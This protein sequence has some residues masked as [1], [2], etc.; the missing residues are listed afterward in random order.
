MLSYF[1][2]IILT[3][4]KP[5]LK[6]VTAAD[7]ASSLYYFHLNTEDDLR[8]LEDD[9][10]DVVGETSKLKEKPLP[11]KPLPGSARSSIDL[12]QSTTSISSNHSAPP[13][14]PR[15]KPVTSTPLA[16]A[17]QQSLSQE[18]QTLSRRPLGP[19]PL[20]L[21]PIPKREILSGVENRPWTPTAR[22]DDSA[23]ASRTSYDTATSRPSGD[24]VVSKHG[25]NKDEAFSIT[26]IRRDPSSGAQWNVGS[27]FGSPASKELNRGE[28]PR[29]KSK[30]THS[31]ISVQILTP[32][33]GTFRVPAATNAPSRTSDSP[34]NSVDEVDTDS[35]QTPVGSD[36]SFDRQVRMEGASFW[37]RPSIQHRRTLTDLSGKHGITHRRGSSGSSVVEPA[38]SSSYNHD[39]ELDNADL[40]SKGYVFVSP[41]GGRCKFSTGSGGRSLTLKHALPAPVSAG[42]TSDRSSQQISAPVSE[43]RFNLPSTAFFSSSDTNSSSKRSS[44]DSK[45]TAAS[46]IRNLRKKLSPHK[47]QP[48]LPPRPHPTSYAALYPSDEDGPPLPPRSY[49]VTD[50]SEEEARPPLPTRPFSSAHEIN[51]TDQEIA[52]HIDDDPHLDLSIGQE[53]AGGGNRGKRAKLGKLVIHHEGF[54]MLDLVVAANIGIWWSV[55]ES[56]RH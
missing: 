36:W 45:T 12:A 56:G 53:K 55:W 40:Q 18:R 16:P 52:E 8:F 48:Q 6:N 3:T 46:A 1:L 17:L 54:K 19:R 2:D 42:G 25:A 51:A 30:K 13:G 21:D 37:S 32:G 34:L 20:V 28:H 22:S 24:I 14:V 31:N 50:S 27:V 7:V 38:D 9:Q 15:R 47:P 43:I 44:F 23:S 5:Q 49:P 39:P 11:R 41:W 10:P 29:R 26:V 33:Y 4:L 35:L